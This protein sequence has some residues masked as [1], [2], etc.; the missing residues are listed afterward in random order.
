[1]D[2]L[3]QIIQ[4]SLFIVAGLCYLVNVIRKYFK[5]KKDIKLKEFEKQKSKDALFEMY[6]RY[7]RENQ[8]V[9]PK[10]TQ[11][12]IKELEEEQGE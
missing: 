7:F 6:K 12:E 8:S 1:M 4:I 3:L 11:Q 5:N 9:E 10:S 2:I